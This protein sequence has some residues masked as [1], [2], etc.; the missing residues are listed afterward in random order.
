MIRRESTLFTRQS[1][2]TVQ[3]WENSE[4]VLSS[5]YCVVLTVGGIGFLTRLR[6]VPVVAVVYELDVL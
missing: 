6:S 3:T 4:V 2:V 5:S 1:D